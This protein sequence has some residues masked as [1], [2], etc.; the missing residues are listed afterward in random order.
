M[1]KSSKPRKAYRPK[2]VGS[3]RLAARPW[4]IDAVFAPIERLLARMEIDGTIDD[5]QGRA[6]FK[7]DGGWYEVVP[8]LRGVIEFHELAT[9]RYGLP[10]DTAA[11]RRL[12]NKLEVNSPLFEQDIAAARRD[13]DSCKRQAAQLTEDQAQSLLNTTRLAIALDEQRAT[14]RKAA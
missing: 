7:E 5:A 8:A 4:K 2:P 9:Q 14:Q 13:I 12:A 3:I 10:A 1:P 6:I 11:L